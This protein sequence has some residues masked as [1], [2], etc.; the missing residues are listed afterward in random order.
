[1]Q[2]RRRITS[3]PTKAEGHG[4]KHLGCRDL[5]FSDLRIAS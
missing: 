5:R 4:G 3:C 2:I 1:L